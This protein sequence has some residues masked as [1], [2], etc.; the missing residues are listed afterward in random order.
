[1]TIALCPG[2]YDPI[3]NGH[4]DVIRRAS[5]LF[6]RV[7]VVIAYNATKK[8]MFTLEQR[9]RFCVAACADMQNVT[10][11]T[12]DGLLVDLAKQLHATVLVKGLR[13]ATDF[14]YE[15]PMQYFNHEMNSSLET[16]FLASSP[17]YLPVSST[18]IR[19]LLQWNRDVSPYVPP[20]VADLLEKEERK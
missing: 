7:Y 18:L 6:D 12:H 17:Q 10:V 11:L 9:E 2:T 16:V 1:M 20:V 15:Y 5:S 14:E 13:N 8:T 3:T 4:L 19:E